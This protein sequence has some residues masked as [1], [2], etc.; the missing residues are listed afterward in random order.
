MAIRNL[1]P[2]HTRGY[3][4]ISFLV[5]IFLL[6]AL[7]ENGIFTDNLLPNP[8][9]IPKQQDQDSR[10]NILPNGLFLS[11]PPK[12]QSLATTTVSWESESEPT[13]VSKTK[14]AET[15][16]ETLKQA[17]SG[18]EVVEEELLFNGLSPKDV[19]ILVKTGAT[20][21]WRR[22]PGHSKY[23]VLFSL[24]KN[25]IFKP[26]TPFTSEILFPSFK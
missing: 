9:L 16:K 26:L 2:R 7:S 17:G 12:A 24:P 21:L 3:L 23:Q 8:V 5:V 13:P 1:V 6:M 25:A 11:I 10:Y 19:V 20:S 22:M 15:P 18:K 14:I 4:W